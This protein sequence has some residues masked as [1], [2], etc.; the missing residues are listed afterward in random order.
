MVRLLG[1]F[2][3]RVPAR[4]RATR[5]LLFLALPGLV[6][7][8][9][10]DGGEDAAT[11]TSAVATSEGSTSTSGAPAALEAAAGSESEPMGDADWSVGGHDLSSQRSNGFEDTLGAD[12]VPNLAVAWE[13]DGLEAVVGT[14]SVVD[15]VVYVG[16]ETGVVHA[17][18]AGSGDE[19]WSTELDGQVTGALAVTDDAV[20]AAVGTSTIRLNRETG[21]QEWSVT[22]DDDPAAV[23]Y[24]SPVVVDG[25]VIQPVSA[26]PLAPP[27]DDYTFRGSVVAL[28]EATGDEQWRTYMTA[29]DETSGAGVSVWAG[30]SADAERHLVFVGTG[31]T[32]E[33]PM[34]PLSDSIVAIDDTTG[35]IAWS[36]QFTASDVYHIGDATRTEGRDADVGST[37]TLWSVGDRDLVGA[38][39]KAGMFHALDRETG[40]VV[41]ETQLTPGSGSGGVIGGSA[42]ADGRLFV[43][44]NVGDPATNLSTGVAKLF[45]LD[46]GTGE[47]LWQVDAGTGVFGAASVADGVVYQGTVDP[48]MEAFDAESG[49]SLWKYEPGGSVGG[50]PSVVDGTLYWGYG[51]WLGERPADPKGGLLAFT[52]G[53]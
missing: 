18:D 39:D 12:Q 7:A 31:N 32:Y 11:D 25:L 46:A 9:S 40:D 22:V 48:A 16:D 4:G 13:L 15:G 20:Y 37:P 24:G 23:L 38:G 6:V 5:F 26:N 1:A 2:D 47:I 44:S 51:F 36:T 41:W 42:Y 3:A 50:G 34:S 53:G 49:A 52:A 35:E 30:A 43:S 28:D 45:A 19:E 17:V 27:Q 8:C 29:N 21:E 14:P 33:D 10:D